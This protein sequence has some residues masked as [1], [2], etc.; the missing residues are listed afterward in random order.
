MNSCIALAEILIGNIK[1]NV[2]SSMILKP[3]VGDIT[4]QDVHALD[5][6]R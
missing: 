4:L 1:P 5:D 6:G 2:L 3:A